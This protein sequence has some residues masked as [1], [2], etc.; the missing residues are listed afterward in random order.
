MYYLNYIAASTSNDSAVVLPDSRIV[1]CAFQGLENNAWVHDQDLVNANNGDMVL[2]GHESDRSV[3]ELAL[4]AALNKNQTEHLIKLLRRVHDKHE[5]FTITNQADLRALWD[6]SGTRLTPP[7]PRQ[8][9]MWYRSLWDWACDLVKDPSVGPHCIFNV[10]RLSKFDGNS[11]IRLIDEPYTTDSFWNFQTELLANGKVLTFILYADKAK[12]SSFGCKKGYPVVAR[13]ANLPAVIQ[14]SKGLS[15]GQVVGWLPVVR[16][17][18]GHTGKPAWA[19]FKMAVWHASFGVLLET[20]AR[21]SKS[22]CW[23]K[24]WDGIARQ[25]FPRILILSAD[26]E[27]Q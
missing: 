24:C 2:D 20:I 1:L 12:L 9:H 3:A 7:K 22:G 27:E 13:L 10:Q 16:E 14:N 23:V 5:K 11:F 17:E 4:E 6:A 15:G 26:Y 21:H 18:K 19:N 25:L 8:F